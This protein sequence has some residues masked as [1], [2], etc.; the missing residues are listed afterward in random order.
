M[1]APWVFVSLFTSDAALSSYA[2]WAMRIYMAASCLFGIQIA[3]QQTFISM[4]NAKVSV[5]LALLRKVILLIPMIYI[6][7]H[8]FPNQAMAVFLAEPVADACA[9]SVTLFLFISTFRRTLA[10]MNAEAANS[11]LPTEE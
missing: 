4:G 9:V 11:A 5:F 10:Q 6:F 7:P 3:C 1:F 2:V 8:I